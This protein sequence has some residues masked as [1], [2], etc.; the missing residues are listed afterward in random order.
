MKVGAFRVRTKFQ[1]IKKKIGRL[2][3]RF[4]KYFPESDAKFDFIWGGEKV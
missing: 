2:M 4:A 1:W 3:Y